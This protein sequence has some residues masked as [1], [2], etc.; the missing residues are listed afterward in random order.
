MDTNDSKPVIEPVG[1]E[2]PFS[3]VVIL[4]LGGDKLNTA[5]ISS[6]IG[7]NPTFCFEKGDIVHTK[8]GLE[9]VRTTGRWVY[10][11]KGIVNSLAVQDHIDHILSKLDNV[12]CPLTALPGVVDSAVS[13]I[14]STNSLGDTEEFSIESDRVRRLGLLDIGLEFVVIPS[15]RV[16]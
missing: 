7:F 8:S 4:G 12:E 14:L 6:L 10:E 1:C 11:T 9:I 15:R 2:R 13:C 3:L 5:K 16:S